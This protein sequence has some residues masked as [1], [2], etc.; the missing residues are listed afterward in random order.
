[1]DKLITSCVDIVI[2][3]VHHK[4]KFDLNL[5]FIF[6]FLFTT[7]DNRIFRDKQFWQI[8]KI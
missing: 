1:M 7:K 4:G 8:W 6:E 3:C 2:T 5:S